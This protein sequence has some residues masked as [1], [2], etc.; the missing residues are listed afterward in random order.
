[1]K[2]SANEAP[3]RLKN[4]QARTLAAHKQ[5]IARQARTIT[6]H[7]KTIAEQARTITEHK[8][9]IAQ[10]EKTIDEQKNLIYAQIEIIDRHANSIKIKDKLYVELS[11]MLENLLLLLTRA[12]ELRDPYTKGHSERVA[13]LSL[14][15]ASDDRVNFDPNKRTA[16]RYAA[17]LHDIGKIGISDFVLHKA[18]KLTEAEYFMIQ[19]H[20]VLGYKLIK[21]LN[22]DP[23]IASV[24]LHHHEN[25]DGSGYPHG[26]KQEEIP[27]AACII[28][29]AD[30]YDA[31]TSRCPYRSPYSHQETLEIFRNERYHYDPSLLDIFIELMEKISP[32]EP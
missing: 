32:Y 19:Q 31:L 9:T 16:L 12:I 17:L 1:M 8:Q 3:K 29:L 18:T 20:T 13:E 24:L 21:P 2:D 15:L 6:E 14:K 5:T 22:L 23:L 4:K 10:Q 25:Y 28:K 26:L 30:I 7:E 27:P 11:S